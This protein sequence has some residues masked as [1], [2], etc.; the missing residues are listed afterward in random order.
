MLTL[1][2]TQSPLGGDRYL[3]AAGNFYNAGAVRYNVA[4]TLAERGR[5]AEARLYAQ[6]ALRNFQHYQ[7]RAANEEQRAQQLLAWIERA[8]ET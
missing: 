3:E 1:R 8:L 2:L 6:A 7:G 4:V 5:L